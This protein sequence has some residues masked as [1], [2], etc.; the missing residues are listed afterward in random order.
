LKNSGRESAGKGKEGD[1]K[2]KPIHFNMMIKAKRQASKQIQ[3]KAFSHCCMV[4]NLGLKKNIRDRS[5]G[6]CREP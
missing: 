1:E 2:A 6:S 3:K 5:E 4:K